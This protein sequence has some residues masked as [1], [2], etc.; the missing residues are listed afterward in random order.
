FRRAGVKDVGVDEIRVLAHHRPLLSV[1]QRD[2]LMVG[3]PVPVRQVQGVDGV[4]PGGGKP[5]DEPPW[6]LGVYE[7]LHGPTGW[8]RRVRASRA[9]KARA[10][11][12][13]SRSRSS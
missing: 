8:G 5:P 1:R 11:R 13:S 12:R 2:D 3:C 10:A 7:E 9:A 6:Q 4:A